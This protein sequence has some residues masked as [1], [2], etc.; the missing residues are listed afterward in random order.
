[1]PA[2]PVLVFQSETDVILLG[3][4]RA[5]Q[6]DSDARPRL[7]AG[8]RVARRHLHH[9]G[10]PAR[11]RDAQPRALRQAGAAD[12]ASRH[13]L[14]DDADQRR[15]P[16]ALRRPRP[17]CPTWCAGPPEATRH[18]ARRG[19]SSTRR[20]AATGS[21]S[22]AWPAAAS[23]RRGPTCPRPDFRAWARAGSGS[24]PCSSAAPS[25]STRPRWA[26]CTREGRTSIS[27]GSTASLDETIAAGFILAEDRDEML[28][29][30]AATPYPLEV[31]DK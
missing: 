8:R 2:C 27:S 9:P 13:G 24:S 18:R 25:P 17:R 16:P 6:P 28:A 31:S 7:G 14:H 10:R 23:A 15:D 30:V 19:S 1:M 21:T 3:G 22:R 29:L 12:H 11:R 4:G 26:G 5:A 20:R